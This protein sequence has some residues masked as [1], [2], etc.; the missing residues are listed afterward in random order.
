VYDFPQIPYDAH[1]NDFA[2][3]SWTDLPAQRMRDAPLAPPFGLGPRLRLGALRAPVRRLAAR[4]PSVAGP[5]HAVKQRLERAWAIGETEETLDTR[6]REDARMRAQEY[7]GYRHVAGCSQCDL[8]A[9]CDGF[10]GDY[11][12]LFGAEEARPIAIGRAVD[13][14]QHYTR[15][16]AKKIHPLDRD[17]LEGESV[18]KAAQASPGL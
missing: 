18:A 9:I 5:L 4:F 10:Y 15:H 11:A 1:E 7:T 17:W 13:D 6:Y 16:Q 14:P 3:W 12:D 2:S 8:R